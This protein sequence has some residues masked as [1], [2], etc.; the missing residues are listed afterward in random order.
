MPQS[1]VELYAAIRH[2]SRAD[3]N[4]PRKKRPTATRMF[5][6]LIDEHGMTAVSYP[7][8]QR[9]V[10]QRRP[11][12]AAEMGRGPATVLI[13]QTHLPGRKSRSTSMTSRCSCAESSPRYLFC[14]RMSFSSKAI[15]RVIALGWPG[16]LLRRSLHALQVLGAHWAGALRQPEI[17]GRPE[18]IAD[19]PARGSAEVV[20]LRSDM[21]TV[22]SAGSPSWHRS[23]AE[24]RTWWPDRL[25]SP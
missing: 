4:A 19:H 20:D 13:P 6:R 16:R 9:Y 25:V 24:S 5:S 2:D 12:I 10:K 17:F 3:V 23:R 15:H 14:F 8:V 18:V 1:R 11:Q 22:A 7:V 21:T